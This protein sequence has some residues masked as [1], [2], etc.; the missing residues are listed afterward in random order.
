MKKHLRVH[1]HCLVF[2]LAVSVVAA[3]ACSEQSLTGSDLASSPPADLAMPVA[4][5]AAMDHPTDDAGGGNGGVDLG[6]PI[7]LLRAPS[8]LAVLGDAVAGGSSATGANGDGGK[9]YARLLY[10]NHPDYPAYEGHDLLTLFPELQFLDLTRKG[11]TLSRTRS[12]LERDLAFMR[13]PSS[14]SGDLV[15]LIHAGS[16]DFFADPNVMVDTTAVQKLADSLRMDLASL[17]QLLKA[18][19]E[20]PQKSVVVLVDNIIDPTDGTGSIPSSYR[21]GLC[22][23]LQSE[24]VQA[25]PHQV[26]AN[27]EYLNGALAAAV[28]ANGAWLVDAHAALLGHGMNAATDRWIDDDCANLGDAGHDVLRRQ[29]W[30]V[31]T[32]DDF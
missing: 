4:G 28:A 31:L 5:D 25:D 22:K 32:G 24:Q 8:T 17:I 20:E 18:H 1:S 30:K 13:L 19:Y 21:D 16:F 10:R 3:G 12:N 15:V 29:A 26:T 2:C 14:P 27:L 23:S 9:G 6:L 11:S 7:K